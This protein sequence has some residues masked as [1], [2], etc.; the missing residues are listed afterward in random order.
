MYADVTTRSMKEA[1]AEVSR[2][3]QVQLEYNKKHGITP[4][5]IQKPIRRKLVEESKEAEELSYE[6]DQK[7]LESMTPSDKKKLIVQWTR[8][9][10]RAS[11]DLD[12]ER[13]AK[14]RDLIAQ[15][16]L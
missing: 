10:R 13:A 8:E 16:S 9:M 6:I 1:I 12:F 7:K 11:R 15:I 5:S 2:R 3:R 14:L 4:Q